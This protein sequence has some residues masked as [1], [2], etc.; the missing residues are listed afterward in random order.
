MLE[1]VNGLIK[2][3]KFPPVLLM[4]GEE[5]FLLSEAYDALFKYFAGQPEKYSIDAFDS[6]DASLNDAID[7]CNSYPFIVEQKAVFIKNFDKYFA[8]KRSKKIPEK[9][10]LT[11]YLKDPPPTT[12]MIL[13]ATLEQ[14]KGVSRKIK[15]AAKRSAAE[16]SLT[17]MAYPYN[18]LF[19]S[20]EWIEF[21]RVYD[22]QYQAW[23]EARAKASG[24]KIAPAAAAYVAANSGDSLRS[25][26]T[27]IDKLL[28]YV[29]DRKDISLED[30]VYLAGDSRKS[31]VFELEKAIGLRALSKS[32]SILKDMLTGKSQEMLIIAMLSRYFTALFKLIEESRRESNQ[33]KLAGAVGVNP[34]FVEDYI[35][36]M[37]KYKPSEIENAFFALVEADERIKTGYADGLTIM[38]ECVMRIVEGR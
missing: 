22:N 2:N 4:F 11:K 29:G 25:L 24:K 5:E 13:T 28:A 9:A 15:S 10:P 32:L 20:H 17:N 16:K 36:A 35:S 12:I 38:T 37:R 3:E 27:E 6:S 7:I 26:Q 21:P 34:Y 18:L 14:I 30:A 8:G 33:F 23:I 31:N 1:N 19:E